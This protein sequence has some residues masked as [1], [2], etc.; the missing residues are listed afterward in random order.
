M[1][2]QLF[3]RIEVRQTYHKLDSDGNKVSFFP[4][5]SIL[6]KFLDVNVYSRSRVKKDKEY[7]S[8]IIMAYNKKSLNIIIDYFKDYP[9]LS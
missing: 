1:R 5:M 6:A 8:F 7:Y 4:I 9:L 2:V 3:F